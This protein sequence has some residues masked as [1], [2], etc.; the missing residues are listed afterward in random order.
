MLKMVSFDFHFDVPDL[1]YLDPDLY[2]I[3]YDQMAW[4]RHILRSIGRDVLA[5]RIELSPKIL[6]ANELISDGLMTKD[7]LLNIYMHPE[8]MEMI[9]N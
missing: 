4:E 8:H 3:L 7:D 2:N 5:Q 1:L 9:S 6:K